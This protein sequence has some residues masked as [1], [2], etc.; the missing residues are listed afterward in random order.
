MFTLD[1]LMAFG[2]NA[3][4][5]FDIFALP[6]LFFPRDTDLMQVILSFIWIISFCS[7]YFIFVNWGT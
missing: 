6:T 4:I 7:N 5:E 2:K 1:E 3:I